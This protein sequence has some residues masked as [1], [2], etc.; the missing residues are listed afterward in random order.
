MVIIFKGGVFYKEKY[1]LVILLNKI[2]LDVIDINIIDFNNIF[3]VKKLFC[4][5]I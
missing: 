5:K 1:L 2:I 3:S 4:F